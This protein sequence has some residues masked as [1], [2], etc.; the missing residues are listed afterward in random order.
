MGIV[1]PVL[2]GIVIGLVLGGLGGGGAILTVPAL[3]FLVGENAAEA[4]TSSVVIVG[5]AAITGAVGHIRSG[6][7]DWRLGAGF[8]AAGIPAAWLGSQLTH[9]V[10]EA[11]LLVGFS[12]LM[13][14][15]A[16]AMVKQP[17]CADSP[18]GCADI[19]A[20]FHAW[21][22]D[23]R[24]DRSPTT[25]PRPAGTPGDG[26][27]AVLTPTSTA[28]VSTP[29]PAVAV[30]GVLV[31]FLTGFFGVGGG[32]VIVPALVLVLGL[33]MHRA[34]GTS[35]VVVALNSAT[36]LASR[37]GT[38]EFDWSVIVPF[39]LA[40]MTATLLGRRLAD[41]LPGARLRSGFAALLVAVAAYT[42]LNALL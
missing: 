11:V 19:R 1:L 36:A 13:A 9:Q 2:L 38:A 28:V 26:A 30:V 3:V 4:T 6:R 8:A 42:A 34:V 14:L 25:A 23:R 41:R 37:A 33:P 18:E 40:A 29:W 32:F 35:L 20:R 5:L 31:G 24:T 27:V 22:T 7:V 10:D 17:T 15:A 21:V 12:V 39:A 16:V